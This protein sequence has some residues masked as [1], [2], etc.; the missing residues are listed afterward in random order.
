MQP[1]G[2]AR[3][4]TLLYRRAREPGLTGSKPIAVF[5]NA[6]LLTSMVAGSDFSP[7]RRGEPSLQALEYIPNLARRR[8]RSLRKSSVRH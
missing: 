2:F 4:W 3:P 6:A 5:C 7:F 1:E 8:K